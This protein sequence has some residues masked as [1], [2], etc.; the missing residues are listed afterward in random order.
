MR[1]SAKIQYIPYIRTLSKRHKQ[2]FTTEAPI[3]SSTV[4]PKLHASP[5][6]ENRRTAFHSCS[7]GDPGLSKSPTPSRPRP[8]PVRGGSPTHP[9]PS[10]RS[11]RIAAGHLPAAA[12]GLST[13][14]DGGSSS[15]SLVA[16]SRDA[17]APFSLRR[18]VEG[19]VPLRGMVAGPEGSRE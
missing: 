12:A 4:T 9:A 14:P 17:G 18:A 13:R 5:T 6:S 8:A 1:T 15:V 10:A 16:A 19:W 7:T 2:K 11:H 3:I